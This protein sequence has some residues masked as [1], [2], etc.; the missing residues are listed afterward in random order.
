M[1]TGRPLLD[2]VAR[3]LAGE[4]AR[5]YRLAEEDALAR[6][7]AAIAADSAFRQ[8]LATAPNLRTLARTSI[9]AQLRRALAARTYDVLRTYHRDQSTRDQLLAALDT[10][11]P[12]QFPE[13][14]RQLAA[15]HVSTA[16]RLPHLADFLNGLL[17]H[18]RNAGTILDAGCGLL[19][20]L[21]PLGAELRPAVYTALD[22]D[23]SSVETLSRWAAAT[24]LPFLESRQW[25]LADGWP[26][27]PLATH[28]VALLLKLV[29]VIDR[30]ERDRLP[31][32]ARVPARRLVLSGSRTAMVK[33]RSIER[34]E[35]AVLGRFLDALPHRPV[36]EFQTGDE[37]ILVVDRTDV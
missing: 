2:E 4:L 33:R 18:L 27:L 17:P 5:K 11:P 29:P 3:V 8:A 21:L 23:R 25:I 35:R 19:P 7:H 16:E 15:L 1:E 12:A 10:A 14:A 22:R 26:D 34:R 31:L 36:A 32:L 24:R 37:F 6:V 9:Y 30:Q 20:L 28:D 13:I